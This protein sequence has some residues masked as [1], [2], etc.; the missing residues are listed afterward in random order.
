M[1]GQQ[2]FPP[3]VVANERIDLSHLSPF[4]LLVES[5]LA[6][7]KLRVHVTFSNHCFSRS[8][9]QASPPECQVIIDQSAPRLRAFCPI[10][11][12]LSRQLPQL[13][14]T[15]NHPQAKV[16]ETSTE[17]NWC[18]SI[19]I[20]DP[21]GPYH[22]FFEIRRASKQRR[23]W[24]DLQLVV[25]SAYH[26]SDKAAPNLKGVVGFVLL[27]GKVYLGKAVSTKR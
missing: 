21:E 5:R 17:R 26:Q 3:L 16:L 14:K 10:R 25:E 18:Y 19:T 24:Q 27:C 11:F 20:D 9:T 6:K 12:R 2:Y 8:Y 13:I 23:Q 7:R 1:T 15:L 22:V 4:T